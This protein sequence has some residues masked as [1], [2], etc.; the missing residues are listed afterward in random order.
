MVVELDPV[1]DSATGVLQGFNA[2]TV[3]ALLLKCLD[4]PLHHAVLLQSVG[5]DAFLLKTIAF[6]QSRVAAAGESQVAAEPNRKGSF[7]PA[8]RS[9]RSG[10]A[11]A[12]FRRYERHASPEAH[13]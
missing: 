2:M 13:G 6:D 12:S 9:G 5:R 4:H 7:T 10:P 8:Y 11:P 3:D 1:A